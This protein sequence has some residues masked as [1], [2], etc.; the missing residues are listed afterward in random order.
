MRPLFRTALQYFQD[1]PND[2]YGVDLLDVR[3]TLT[4]VMSDPSVL[5]GWQIVVDGKRP[6]AGEDDY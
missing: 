6:E 2:Y 3:T 4:N 1:V 5:D